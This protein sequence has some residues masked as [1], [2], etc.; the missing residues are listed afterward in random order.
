MKTNLMIGHLAF[1]GSIGPSQLGVSHAGR[2]SASVRVYSGFFQNSTPVSEGTCTVCLF[3]LNKPEWKHMLCNSTQQTWTALMSGSTSES[4]QVSN[5]F[6]DSF[7]VTDERESNSTYSGLFPVCIAMA[8]SFSCHSEFT[9]LQNVRVRRSSAVVCPV[10]SP[11]CRKAKGNSWLVTVSVS[12]LEM[13][14]CLRPLRNKDKLITFW[15][16]K[17]E[18]VVTSNLE[19][20]ISQ[21]AI[22]GLL[23]HLA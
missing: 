6:E 1:L 16:S 15:R 3:S 14:W 17:V 11:L 13:G 8:S 23:S 7:R 9:H 4:L 12:R 19:S 2:P 20:T 21:E 10:C 5:N 22:K 18:I